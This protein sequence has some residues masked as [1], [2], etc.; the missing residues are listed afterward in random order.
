MPFVH[1]I[2]RPTDLLNASCFP[3]IAFSF[4]CWK[5]TVRLGSA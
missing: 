1:R 2:A 5:E 3:F 4:Y